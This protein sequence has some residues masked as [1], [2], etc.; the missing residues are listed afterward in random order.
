MHESKRKEFMR[1]MKGGVAIFPSALPALRTHDVEYEYRQ[2]SNFY[3][4]TG[5]E[6]PGSIC[7]LAPGH[8]E[9]QF[10][11][12][13][14]PHDPEQEV[15]TGKRVGVEGGKALIGADEAYPITEFDQ[16][17]HEYLKDAN[18]IYYSFGF[19]EVFNRKIVE[20]C[21]RYGRQ[22]AQ[23]GT[24][25]NT[26]IDPGEILG[27]M[28][29]IKSGEELKRIR[30]ATE[31]TADAQIT[32]MKTLHPGQYEYEI[33]AM[34]DSIFRTSEGSKTGFPTIVA[35]AANAATLHYT[36]NNR[37]I[38]D[39]DLV[40]IDAG[41]E[42]KYYSGD[43]TRTYPANGRFTSVQREIYQLVLECQLAAI[44]AIRPGVPL[45][46]PNKKS[47]ALMTEGMLKIGLLAG[48]K[49][50]LIAEE[51]HKQ[52]CRHGI[53]HMLGLDVHDL[54]KTREGGTHKTFQPG[55]V[56][57]VEPGLYIA[58]DTENVNPKYLGIGVRIEDDVLV[59]T[60]GCEVLTAKVP[61]T[62][63]EIERLM[64]KSKQRESI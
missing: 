16:K 8:P 10:V 51:K 59:T 61:K 41:C 15:W 24:G 55:M 30:R 6:E 22:R 18:Q 53:G 28:R 11:L 48:E 62:I 58:A 43:I 42:Y 21:K 27:E 44:E 14:N 1:K 56:F 46:E 38:Q 9:H 2:D 49:E 29:L 23:Q 32:A 54:T 60:S 34:I 31:I 3:Y 26:L 25:P 40:L 19:D 5:F 37:Q 4:L 52:F 64:G 63:D 33:Q 47:I 50:E 45:D 12:F 13:V 17:I 39:G 35:S 57:T 7:V 36:A 20:L